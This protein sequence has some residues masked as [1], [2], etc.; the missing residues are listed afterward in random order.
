MGPSATKKE[1]AKRIPKR[2]PKGKGR[3]SKKSIQKL[4][5]NN[6]PRAAV[7]AKDSRSKARKWTPEED[8]HVRDTVSKTQGVVRWKQMGKRIS[9]T[10]DQCS[11]RWRKVLDP[12]VKRFVK[13]T[14]D[15]DAKLIQIHSTHPDWSNKQVAELMP[16]RTPTQCHNRW[17]DKVNPLLRW[18]TW[19]PTEDSAVWE[20]RKTGASW[21][22]IIQQNSCLV[23]RAHVAVKNRWHS[24]NLAKK[25][26]A[27]KAA[28][29]AAA[30]PG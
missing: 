14:S 5:K 7:A 6:D 18:E 27:K 11:Q 29:L 3:D 15:E 1:P 21:S 23:N 13:W 20:G 24:L 30:T 4:T 9:R 16:D 19:S 17:W 28:K 8:D 22:K 12:N 25:N 26:K 10:G 2:K